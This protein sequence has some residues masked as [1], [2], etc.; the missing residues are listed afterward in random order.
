MF[1]TARRDICE[2]SLVSLKDNGHKINGGN[3]S[4]LWPIL[5]VA[6]N[7]QR[8]AERPAHHALFSIRTLTKSQSEIANGLCTAL[9]TERLGKVESMVLALDPGV[10]NHRSRICLQTRHGT[11]NVLVNLDDLLDR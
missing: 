3:I 11:A 7:E 4:Q 8:N 10:F 1:R 9:N 5:I 6:R 2:R